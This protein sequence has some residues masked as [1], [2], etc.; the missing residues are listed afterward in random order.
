MKDLNKIEEKVKDLM[1]ECHEHGM[2]YLISVVDKETGDAVN[3]IEGNGSVAMVMIGLFVQ[4][5][6][7]KTGASTDEILEH[8]KMA[9]EAAEEVQKELGE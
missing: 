5:V 6:A 3:V 8:V 7:E 1:A 9:V 4:K 2:Q